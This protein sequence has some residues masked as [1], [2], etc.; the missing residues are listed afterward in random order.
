MAAGFG[1]RCALM[2][3]SA[4]FASGLYGPFRYAGYLELALEISNRL[5]T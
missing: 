4:K 1:N 2:S 3:Y 5:E